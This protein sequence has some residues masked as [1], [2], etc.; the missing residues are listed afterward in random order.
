MFGF[1]V[2]GKLTKAGV[3]RDIVKIKNNIVL[4]LAS[5]SDG[6]NVVAQRIEVQQETIEELRLKR[7]VQSSGLQDLNSTDEYVEEKSRVEAGVELKEGQISYYQTF[8]TP[9][10]SAV[11]GV[12]TGKQPKSIYQE[13]LV[14][15]WVPDSILHNQEEKWL[16]PNFF[17]TKTPTLPTSPVSGK[18]VS[19]CESQA[20]TLV[21]AL[22]AIGVSAEEVRVVT[23]KV[24]FGGI[25]GGHAWVELYD[26]DSQSWFQLEATS[27]NYYD[28][29][30]GKYVVSS[31]LPFEYFKTYQYPSIQI[32]TYFNDKYFW[33]NSRRQGVAPDSWLATETQSKK[34]PE[35]EIRYSPPD[36]LRRLRP[37]RIIVIQEAT[38]SGNENNTPLQEWI[39][40]RPQ[41][42]QIIMPQEESSEKEGVEEEELND[43]SP[44][45]NLENLNDKFLWFLK[46][47]FKR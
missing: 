20:Y 31:G 2:A 18:I 43:A 41:E 16:T 13:A 10:D 44:S 5:K 7:L 4:F 36:E 45:S 17:L 24:D 26:K 46:R 23:G 33:D 39:R 14:W 15:V 1:I 25:V 19:D 28:L 8:V 9:N 22:R 35:R 30:T 21:S 42:R 12:A 3:L 32:W 37:E 6:Q 11:Q 29:A 38:S 34:A 27:G 47:R 40:K